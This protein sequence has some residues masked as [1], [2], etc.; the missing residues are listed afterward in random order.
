MGSAEFQDLVFETLRARSEGQPC[1]GVT[2]H[3]SLTPT[4]IGGRSEPHRQISFHLELLQSAPLWL[5]RLS[6]VDRYRDADSVPSWL[7]AC[8]QA[9]GQ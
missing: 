5:L 4:Q 8:G 1:K 6:E 3:P 7:P 2:W 9:I